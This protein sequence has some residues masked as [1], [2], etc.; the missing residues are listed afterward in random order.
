MTS[1]NKNMW[2]KIFFYSVFPLTLAACC[3]GNRKC[4]QD[5]T[6]ARFR[7]VNA[8]NGQDLVFGSTKV[9]DKDLIKFYSLSGTDTILHHYGAGPN[10]NPGQDSLLFVD[11][12]YRKQNI[13]F[14]RL[15]NSDIDTLKIIYETVD[16]SPCCPDYSAARPSSFNNKPLDVLTGGVTI[17]KK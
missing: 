9:Y 10:P 15:S 13:V 4:N 12:D 16:A 8:I 1:M 11:F 14:I 5:Y 17:I 6:S 3:L 2:L 7:I